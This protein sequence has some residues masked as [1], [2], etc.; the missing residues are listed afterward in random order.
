MIK[1]KF[2]SRSGA[3]PRHCGAPVGIETLLKIAELHES[4]KPCLMDI[5]LGVGQGGGETPS[6][7]NLSCYI[8]R[9]PHENARMAL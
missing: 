8:E 6:C 2:I 3:P 1:L 5:L 9:A 4:G 7:Q